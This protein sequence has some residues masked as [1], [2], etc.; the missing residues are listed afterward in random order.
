[1]P[2][3]W[4]E[5]SEQSRGGTEAM[6]RELEKR[7]A[8]DLLDKFQIIPSRV[9]ELDDARIRIL[10]LHNTAVDPEAQSALGNGGW[11][12][13]HRLVFVSNHQMQGFIERYAIPWERCVVMRNAIEP[14]GAHEKPGAPIR[15]IYTSTPQRGLDILQAVFRRLAEKHPDIELEVFSSF[16]LYGWDDADAQFQPMFDRLR[17]QPRIKWH[18]ARPNEE[19]REALRRCHIFSY[20][21]IWLET[22]GIVLME[23]MSAG[24]L[25]V[26]P[27]YGALYETAANLTMMYQWSA[28]MNVHAGVFLRTLDQAI[29]LLKAAP[30]SVRPQLARQQRYADE[31]H[32][33]EQRTAEWEAFLRSLLGL[34]GR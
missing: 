29:E 31:I 6:G 24:L 7:I 26:H 15:L 33:W 23:A 3:A 10:W 20:P 21:S 34:Y 22:S 28:D 16:K 27:N 9:R 17:E 8:P 30:E 4:N 13:F 18:G 25:C 19:V 5:F 11:R 14:V 12:R 32:G 2:I 1:V